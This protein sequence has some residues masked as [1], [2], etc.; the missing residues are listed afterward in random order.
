LQLSLHALLLVCMDLQSTPLAIGGARGAAVSGLP[1]GASAPP[2]R[3]RPSQGGGIAGGGGPGGEGEDEV[4]YLGIIDIL[5][6]YDLRKRGETLF[7]GL[8]Y[9]VAGLSA[10]NPEAYA[11]RFVAFLRANTD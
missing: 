1:P 8:V 9:P 10:V 3:P 4:Y 6:Q 2:P 5:Q 7:K 11:D